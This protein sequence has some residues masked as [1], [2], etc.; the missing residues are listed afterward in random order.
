M[1]PHN[2]AAI[3]ENAGHRGARKGAHD[4]LKITTEDEITLD[5][6]LESLQRGGEKQLTPTTAMIST[7][8]AN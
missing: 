8:K 5:K 3:R 1:F 4:Q 6:F 2:G 7:L